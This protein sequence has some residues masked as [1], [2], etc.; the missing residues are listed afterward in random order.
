MFSFRDFC[1]DVFDVVE[2]T[3]SVQTCQTQFWMFIV[4]LGSCFWFAYM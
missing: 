2:A 1:S 4:V 3:C